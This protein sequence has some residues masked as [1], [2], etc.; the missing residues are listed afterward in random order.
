MIFQMQ[1]LSG[2]PGK[3]LIIPVVYNSNG[4]DS[5]DAAPAE[6]GTCWYYSDIKYLDN[7]LWKHSLCGWLCRYHPNVLREMLDQTGSLKMDSTGIAKSG[8]LV[9]HLYYRQLDNSGLLVPGRLVADIHLSIMSQYSPQYKEVAYPGI[10]DTDRRGIWWDHGLCSFSWLKNAFIQELKSHD[11]PADFDQEFLS[12]SSLYMDSCNA[13]SYT[14]NYREW[15]ELLIG[16]AEEHAD[17]LLIGLL[18]LRNGTGGFFLEPSFSSPNE[19]RC[20]RSLFSPCWRALIVLP[21]G[22]L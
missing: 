13:D 18:L 15:E 21:Y 17:V 14:R 12:L 2:L 8:L 16:L 1:M 4:Y 10:S 7:R 20:S 11:L 5:V 3:G 6:Y 22:P 19:Y 9:R